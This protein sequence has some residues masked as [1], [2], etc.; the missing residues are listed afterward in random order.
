[1]VKRIRRQKAF[2]PDA[3]QL[4]QLHEACKSIHFTKQAHTEHLKLERL[5]ACK[6]F[7]VSSSL[8]QFHE[9]DIQRPSKSQPISRQA[10]LQ[11]RPDSTF[12]RV[13]CECSLHHQKTYIAAL[14]AVVALLASLSLLTLDGDDSHMQWSQQQLVLAAIAACSIFSGNFPRSGFIL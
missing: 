4:Q 13:L 7:M 12:K 8:F 5:A 3:I 2:C 10:P 9:R 6:L 1:M 14:S 11:L